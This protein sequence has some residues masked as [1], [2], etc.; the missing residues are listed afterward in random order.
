M[1]SNNVPVVA[2][3]QSGG[4]IEHQSCWINESLTF[5][6]FTFT[7]VWMVCDLQGERIIIKK[8]TTKWDERNSFQQ[9]KANVPQLECHDFACKD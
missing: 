3:F 8:N 9:A 4:S 7:N 2:L 6:K 1:Q 5:V